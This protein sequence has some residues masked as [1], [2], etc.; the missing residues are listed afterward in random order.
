MPIIGHMTISR[1]ALQP[2]FKMY[3]YSTT[4]V[5]LHECHLYTVL[6]NNFEIKDS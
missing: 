1:D 2:F 5:I 4:S 3:L 6:I